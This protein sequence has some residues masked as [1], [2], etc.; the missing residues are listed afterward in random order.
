MIFFEKKLLGDDQTACHVTYFHQ[1]K[2]GG[3]LYLNREDILRSEDIE[4]FRVD[5]ASH[6]I[7]DG[8]RQDGMVARMDNN[9]KGA[10]GRVG[11]TDK[12]SRDSVFDRN[13]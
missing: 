9:P 11:R 8:Q 7:I 3:K 13:E 2:S 5:E 1:I 12:R 10:H 6:D 4:V